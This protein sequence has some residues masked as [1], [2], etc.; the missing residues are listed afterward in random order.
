[1]TLTITPAQFASL[2]AQLAQAPGVILDPLTP[3]AGT[4]SNSDVE[5]SYSYDGSAVLT[6]EVIARHSLMAKISPEQM[7]DE[8]IETLIQ[9]NLQP[10]QGDPA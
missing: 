8:Q 1:M 9:S 5:L 6:V 4:L 10:S 2:K 3:T 7:I